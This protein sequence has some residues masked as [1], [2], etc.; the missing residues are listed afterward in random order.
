M[1]DLNVMSGE[2]SESTGASGLS[3][4]KQ[5]QNNSD[6]SHVITLIHGTF[7]PKDK[8]TR[9]GSP[10]RTEIE[11][12]LAQSGA[13]VVHFHVFQW[14]G[15]LLPCLNNSDRHRM[16][17]GTKLRAELNRL[18]SQ[19][20][21]SQHY[22]V[23]HSHGGNV[24]LYALREDDVLA[25]RIDGIAFLATPFLQGSARNPTKT[26]K[27]L[28]ELA[29][30]HGL[31]MWPMPYTIGSGVLMNL[32]AALPRWFN[33]SLP[34]AARP[35]LQGT[36]LCLYLIGLVG[37]GVMVKKWVPGWLE[38]AVSPWLVSRQ[39]NALGRHQIPDSLL[40]KLAPKMFCGSASRDEA[41]LFLRGVLSGERL[42]ILGWRK[43]CL[44]VFYLLIV[45]CLISGISGALY[46]HSLLAFFTWGLLPFLLIT[47]VFL[48]FFLSSL[49]SL[50]AVSMLIQ[51]LV[52][53]GEASVGGWL[54]ERQIS[55]TTYG[56]ALV[57]EYG[58]ETRKTRF[59]LTL[60]HNR[61]CERP[62]LIHDL[63]GWI[64]AGT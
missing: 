34:A 39:Q 47:P 26:V 25:T 35:S 63:A 22:I 33:P 46:T 59:P 44:A 16:D 62:E 4:G 54:V 20:P 42:V 11:Q 52:F 28:A 43:L 57:R 58:A 19:H 48:L 2:Y 36:T 17:A 53:G 12:R 18:V 32:I 14:P 7:R 50:R 40:H 8:W 60:R 27:S 55:S 5:I 1:Q 23:T 13:G 49:F 6:P 37:G 29:R 45:G 10:L 21:N 51:L 9:E 30:D 15:S 41:G 24:A 38:R 64:A 61:I 31:L 56:T 3:L